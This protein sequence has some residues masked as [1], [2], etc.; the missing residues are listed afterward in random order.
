MGLTLEYADK[1]RLWSDLIQGNTDRVFVPTDTDQSIGGQVSVELVL[2]GLDVRIQI[3]GVV[4]GRRRRSE[5]F[6][7]GV[8]V[9][10]TDDEIEKCRRFLG[11]AQDPVRYEKGR[12]AVRVGC[13]LKARFLK[14]PLPEHCRV[15]NLSQSGLLF[16]CPSQL[17]ASQQVT[18]EL[19][20]DDE[21]IV[22]L[23]AEVSR[24]PDHE[25]LAGLRFIEP[26]LDASRR[27]HAAVA[28]LS[29][30][31]GQTKPPSLVVADDDPMILNFLDKALSR[32]GYEVHKARRGEEALALVRELR[33]NLV[34]LDILMP[35]IDG[36]D[37]CKMM[38]ADIEMADIPVIFLSALD[39]DRLH[40]VA[41]EAGASDY[42]IKP[43]ALADLINMVGSYL[44]R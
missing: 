25:G 27:I 23:R 19:V 36:V 20:L 24:D 21:S 4:I 1:Y 37:I 44:Q 38:R 14:P 5:R 34:L 12:K 40:A 39:P 13:E 9:R 31:T 41:D 22:E 2:T 16:A 18:I 28:R 7:A 3:S 32:F 17:V 33:P 15:T 6:S 10:F 35:G 26:S 43:V 30:P 11:L 29:V 8:Y 42:L